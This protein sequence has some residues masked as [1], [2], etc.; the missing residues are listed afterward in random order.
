MPKN[1]HVGGFQEPLFLPVSTW[2]RPKELPDLRRVKRIALDTEGRDSGLSAGRGPGWA[3]GAGHITGYSMAWDGGAD[4]YP[5]RDPDTDN[6]EPENVARWVED[7]RKA[8]VEFIFQNSNFDI[9]WMTRE[10]IDAKGWTKIQDTMNAAVMIDETQYT[11]NLDDLCARRGIPGKD[12]KSL[13]EVGAAFGFHKKKD[14]KQ[15]LWRFPARHKAAYAI[16]DGISTLALWDAQQ[17]DLDDQNLWEAYQLEMDLVP[18]VVQMRQRGVRI[19]LERAAAERDYCFGVRDAVFKELRNRIGEKVGMEEIGKTR[20]MERIFAAHAPKIEIPRTPPS[21]NYPD[22]QASFTAGSTGWMPKNP[23]WLCQLIVKA[24]KYNNAAQKFLQGYIIDYTHKG[25]LHASV[26][27][28]LGENEDG[29][30]QGTRTYRFSYSDPPLQQMTSRDSDL[31]PRIRGCFE[32]ELRKLWAAADYSQQEYRLIVHFAWLMEL[33]KADIAGQRYIEDPKTDYHSMVADL[34]GLDRQPAKDTNFA[35][36]YGAGVSKFASMINQS[37]EAAQAIMEQYDR[38]MPFVKELAETCQSLASQRGYIR[39]LDGARS[40]FPRWELAWRPKGEAYFPP[41]TLEKAREMWPGKRLK[42]AD[43]KDA[44]NRLIQGSAA[45]QTKKAMRA[46]YRAGYLPLLQMHDELDFEL[47]DEKQGE[48][49]REIMR[50]IHPLK[51][52]MQ[53]DVEYGPNWGRAAKVKLK[54]KSV[55]YKAT[56]KEALRLR[57]EGQWWKEA[58]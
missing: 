20:W 40:H 55:P 33:T 17:P 25:R 1:P 32:P 21:K 57:D 19:N 30:L 36:S 6:F 12:E 26:N 54:D 23:H 52:P 2:Q 46:A 11:Y 37:V 24:D 42:R 7:H 29:S 14:I 35:K 28:L 18:M 49:I 39:L 53:V 13:L 8:G 16:Q 50:D 10:G 3:I 47:E 41:Q 34:T 4:Y 44:M 9:G 15:N 45:R 27:Q 22:G 31:A 56:W 48:E 58:A 51:V 38:E 43:T 5:V